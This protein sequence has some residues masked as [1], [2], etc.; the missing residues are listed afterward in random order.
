MS[1]DEKHHNINYDLA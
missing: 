1:M